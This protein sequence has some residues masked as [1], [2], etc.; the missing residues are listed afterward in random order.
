MTSHRST[1]LVPAS[2]ALLA[3]GN[4]AHAQ[5]TPPP[6][7]PAPAEAEEA[8][9]DADD[10][11]ILAEP[12][13]QVRIDRRTYTL[14]DDPAAQST[15]MFDVLGRVPSVSVAPSG[16]VTL[17]G[18]AD[19]TI[20][21]NGQ[22][23]PGNNLEQVL[24]GITGAEVERIEVITNPSAQYSAQAS[25]GIINIITRQRI[26][27]GF[28][29]NAQA[30]YDTLDSYH[31]GISPTWS[32]GPWSLSGSIGAFGG[33]QNSDFQRDREI[34]SSG[35][36]TSETGEQ[37]ID[38]SGFYASRL[39]VGYRFDDR[40]RMSAAIDGVSADN[41]VE[42]ATETRDSGGLLSEQV[43]RMDN[44]FDNR[45]FIFDAQQTG[46][47]PRELLK[48]NAVA[49]RITFTSD[50]S[51]SF[52]PNG[53]P[54]SAFETHFGQDSDI[55]NT[56]LDLERPFAETHFLTA[57]LAFDTLSQDI[58]NARETVAGPVVVPDFD[59]LLEGRAQTLAAYATY[60]FATGDWT[61]QPGLRAEN[62]RRKVLS[63]G[64]ETDTTD[65]EFFPSIHIRRSLASSMEL[66]L[67]YTRRISRPGFQQ[68]DPS[69]RFLDVDRAIAGNPD[70]QSPITDAYEAN[71]T[72]QRGGA[73]FGVTFYDRI[74]ED[75]LSPFVEVL[76]DGTIVTTMVN[77][78]TSEQR[79]LQAI[80]R[81]PIGDNWRYSLTANLLNREFDVLNGTTL[82]QRSEFEYDG[83]AQIDYSDRD[84]NAIG[85]NQIQL[86]VRFQGPR[87][88]LQSDFDEFIVA[89]ATWRRRL[90]P[91]LFGV[92][93]VQDI[94]DSQDQ[95]QEITTTDYFERSETSSP[96][97]RVR[98][99]LT[100]QFG[101]PTG[102]P[103]PP[104]QQ[105]GAPPI[106]Q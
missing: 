54:E 21:V 50:Q 74:T 26:N 51:M 31:A 19:V 97:T 70:L 7:P 80:L 93:S 89:N 67:S 34:F 35:D 5:Q 106:P 14:R 81:G 29:G 73:T 86:E 68:L 64:L 32:R 18:A 88:T 13:D 99:A 52:T 38:Y 33:Q 1:W 94:F 84:Q 78:G 11:V 75:V 87:H 71:L 25:G 48:F 102:R 90:T 39:Q 28:S 44:N 36:T 57:G 63:S 101:D 37:A 72:Y 40:R 9:D 22:P 49:Q 17:L 30:S 6:P 95:V 62:Y 105:M 2:L 4:V 59:T 45:Q 104:E 27:T 100:Y 85:A 82:S 83:V 42:R 53:G 96:G 47:L 98:F 66:D 12:G 43:T 76:P 61:W 23:V 24:R 16:A 3:V 92:L 91:R 79:G 56:R 8:I 77:A 41:E 69:L 58:E 46:A 15:N 65:L 103:P 20:Q 55:V 60:Q 10:I